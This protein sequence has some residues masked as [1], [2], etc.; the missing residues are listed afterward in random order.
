MDRNKTLAIV[1]S[2]AVYT[3]WLFYETSR[4]RPGSEIDATQHGVHSAETQ[5]TQA[6]DAP[7]EPVRQEPAALAAEP[8]P[9]QENLEPMR[10]VAAWEG[11]FAGETFAARLTNRGAALAAWEL[12]QFWELD[13]AGKRGAPIQ[14]L[15]LDAQHPAA[16]EM[17]F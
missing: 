7:G 17:P 8:S 5:M 6:D 2:L 14:L 12:T 11:E 10:E 3:L 16:L 4:E 1:L 13:E 15:S 9:S